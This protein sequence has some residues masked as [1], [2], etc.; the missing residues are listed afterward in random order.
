M[1]F[2][3]IEIRIDNESH[4]LG[5][6]EVKKFDH[7]FFNQLNENKTFKSTDIPS[8]KSLFNFV[9]DQVVSI[10]AQQK[11]DFINTANFFG[12][13]QLAEFSKNS[14][15]QFSLSDYE[16]YCEEEP[17]TYHCATQE[18]ASF[19]DNHILNELRST[20]SRENDEKIAVA[21]QKEVAVAVEQALAPYRSKIVE[22]KSSESGFESET[23][24]SVMDPVKD[25]PNQPDVQQGEVPAYI[26]RNSAKNLEPLKENQT[27]MAQH[28]PPS[29]PDAINYFVNKIKFEDKELNYLK[30]KKD[31]RTLVR[32]LEK[33]S[34]VIK[35]GNHG[36]N[37]R[38]AIDGKWTYIIDFSVQYRLTDDEG[39][40]KKKQ[41][42]NV[43]SSHIKKKHAKREAFNKLIRTAFDHLNKTDQAKLRL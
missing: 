4:E 17:P 5:T 2:G 41:N 15:L 35:I 12:L 29:L 20:I 36:L 21:V 30:N 16:E 25:L 23:L 38:G 40:H 1:K 6:S 33:S 37:V 26:V 34:Q 32:Y 7:D 11:N 28:Q 43:A 19:V 24:K 18:N 8:W 22:D 3:V 13:S 27:F 10:S 39:E 42:F 31:G 14:P 9:T